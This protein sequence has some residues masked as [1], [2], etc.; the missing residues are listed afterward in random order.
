M[1][2]YKR[3]IS[4]QEDGFVGKVILNEEVVYTTPSLKDGTSV[5]EELNKY[6]QASI[7]GIEKA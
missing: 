5:S 1:N 3:T 2:I 6:I 7:K 4:A